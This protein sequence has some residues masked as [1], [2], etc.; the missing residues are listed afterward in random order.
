MTSNKSYD[1]YSIQSES[2]E[3][4]RSIV[5]HALGVALLAHESGYRGGNYYRLDNP[6]TENLLLQ[7]NRI[8][9]DEWAEPNH[10]GEPFLFYVNGTIRS[11]EL[12][13]KLTAVASVRRLK[14][15]LA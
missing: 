2:L 10:E 1:L 12:Y 15:E 6:S 7:P 11:D 14:H 4:A 8:S 5:E 9:D 3:H 13:A